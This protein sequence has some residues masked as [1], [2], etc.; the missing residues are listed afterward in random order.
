[1][2]P[3]NSKFRIMA[4]AK[5]P[6]HPATKALGLSWDFWTTF[7]WINTRN[8]RI[9]LELKENA[10]AR[11]S[12]FAISPSSDHAAHAISAVHAVCCKAGDIAH[13][14]NGSC[15]LWKQIWNELRFRAAEGEIGTIGLHW[16]SGT[17]VVLSTTAWKFA[18]LPCD[19][20]CLELPKNLWWKE[21]R[22]DAHDVLQIYKEEIDD[23]P[24]VSAATLRAWIEKEI[25]GD[26]TLDELILRSQTAFPKNRRPGRQLVRNTAKE[27]GFSPKPGPKPRT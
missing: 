3:L 14:E 7:A 15:E 6:D 11:F 13:A 17:P 22:F 25:A 20:T 12:P 21:I 4:R 27:L 2:V 5:L 18:Q 1:M 23:R 16:N 8:V 10:N 19:P 26:I 24:Y 9:G